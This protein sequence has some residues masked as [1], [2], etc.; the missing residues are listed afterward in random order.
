MGSA[1]VGWMIAVGV[2]LGLL[3]ILVVVLVALCYYAYRKD[4]KARER[5]IIDIRAAEDADPRAQEDTE[6]RGKAAPHLRIRF[7]DYTRR[8]GDTRWRKDLDAENDRPLTPTGIHFQTKTDRD[9]PDSAFGSID[10]SNAGSVDVSNLTY[11]RCE[12]LG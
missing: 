3:L 4:M 11:Y 9:S 1:S 6:E 12:Y 5:K 8:K 7:P 10:V 2:V